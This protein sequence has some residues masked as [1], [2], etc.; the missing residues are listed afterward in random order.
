MNRPN[1]GKMCDSITA[2]LARSGDRPSLLL[3]ACCAPCSSAVLEYLDKYFD[4]TVFFFNP[5]IAPYEEYEFRL[6]ELERF[7][8]EVYGG[9]I[10][11]I[12]PG[13]DHGSFLERC[14][15]L[16]DDPEGGE[17][18]TLC[19]GQR[20]E[21]TARVASSG[22]Y[23]Y[24]CTTLSVS[25]YKDPV[26]INGLG[27]SFGDEYGVRF[28]PSDFKKNNG[29]A[30]SVELSKQYGLYRQNYCGCPFSKRDPG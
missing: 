25:P 16:N 30:R 3:H 14:G 27:S 23:D 19:Y 4:I 15:E 24:F 9:R 10:G 2:E 5:N 17:R 29:Y 20:L 22:G 11:I 28:L 26:R 12:S 7:L 8:S 18:C 6:R 13:W 1:Y 21:E